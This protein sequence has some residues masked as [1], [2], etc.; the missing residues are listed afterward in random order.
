MQAYNCASKGNAVPG[1]SVSVDESTGEETVPRKRFCKLNS[2]YSDSIVMSSVGQRSDR[3]DHTN[4]LNSL[5]KEM[6]SLYMIV[7]DMCL[8]EISDRFNE[9]S[10]GFVLALAG[11]VPGS[12][13]FLDISVLGPLIKLVNID[14]TNLSHELHVAKPMVVTLLDKS[15]SSSAASA[16]F[17]KIQHLLQLLLPFRSAFPLL[18][19]LMATALT[20]GASTAVCENSFSTLTRVLTPHRRSTLHR[21]LSNLVILA[22]E[23]DITANLNREKF[24]NVFRTCGTRRLLI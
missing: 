21:R 5:K 2:R 23:K 4:N 20:F 15:T 8:A 10:N 13:G 17:S 16:T 11:L 22:F 6:T 19:K 3:S 14:V 1:D 7:I 18:I 24:L 12:I 9:R